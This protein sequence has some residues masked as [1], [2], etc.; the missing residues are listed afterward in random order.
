MLMVAGSCSGGIEL[1]GN[2][3][4]RTS[5]KQM[6]NTVYKD[7]RT[8][9]YFVTENYLLTFSGVA[10]QVTTSPNSAVQPVDLVLF[11]E[12]KNGNPNQPIKLRAAGT[13]AFANPFLGIPAVIDCEAETAK[14]R[15]AAKFMSDGSEPVIMIKNGQMLKKEQ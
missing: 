14:G 5:C 13:C 15:F 8:G 7:G 3:A 9:F 10:P 1:F 12:T 2:K 11:N 6:S 4:G